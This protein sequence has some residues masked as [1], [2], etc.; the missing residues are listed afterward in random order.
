MLLIVVAQRGH[1]KESRFVPI[2][3]LRAALEKTMED[4]RS[5]ISAVARHADLR[6]LNELL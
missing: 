4:V 2:G 5:T 1:L 3:V 6:L